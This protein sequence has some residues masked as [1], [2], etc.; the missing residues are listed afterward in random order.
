MVAMDLSGVFDL[1]YSALKMITEAEAKARERG[2]WLW[3]VGMTPEVFALVQRSPLGQVLGTERMIFNLEQVVARYQALP[4]PP[5]AG[6]V[7]AAP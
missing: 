7:A 1:E 4:A 6:P 5:T 3:L 2:A